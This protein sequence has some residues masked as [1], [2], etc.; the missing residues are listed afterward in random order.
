[1]NKTLLSFRH[2]ELDFFLNRWLAG[3]LSHAE[4]QEWK[5]ILAHDTKFREELC[6]WLKCLRDPGVAR[7]SGLR[8]LS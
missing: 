6:D 7:G 4:L 3:A 1:M 5:R 2:R 8:R